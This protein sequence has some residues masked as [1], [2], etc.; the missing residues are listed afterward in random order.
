MRAIIANHLDLLPNNK[1]V[2]F[3]GPT[4]NN[5]FD[6]GYYNDFAIEW[7][8]NKFLMNDYNMISKIP[9]SNY[10]DCDRKT[11]HVIQN[12]FCITTLTF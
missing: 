8:V 10:F 12:R 7:L 4:Q 5:G 11:A 2:K 9:E 6:C 3:L 1:L